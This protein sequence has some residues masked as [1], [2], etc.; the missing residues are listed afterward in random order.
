MVPQRMSPPPDSKQTNETGKWGQQTNGG[1]PATDKW[2]D[3]E[4]YQSVRGGVHQG[5]GA[6][7]TP[8]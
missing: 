6:R 1:V 8:G 7:L 4:V 2:A 3:P 5:P